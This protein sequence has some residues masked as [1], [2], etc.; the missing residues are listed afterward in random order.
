MLAK[1]PQKINR[2]EN[3]Y[4]LAYVVVVKTRRYKVVNFQSLFVCRTIRT[5]NVP[6]EK[7]FQHLFGY[8]QCGK[9]YTVDLTLEIYI[10]YS[11][12]SGL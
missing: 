2:S 4:T 6:R 3:K 12:R 8:Y 1:R 7:D 11:R 5:T 10:R 9:I